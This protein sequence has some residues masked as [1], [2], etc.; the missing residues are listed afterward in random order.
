MI[1][2]HSHILFGVDDGA[3]DYEESVKMLKEARKAGFDTIIAT[4]H[5][6]RA[7][8]D[9]SA[10]KESMGRL[11]PVAESI[12]INLIQGYE[13]NISALADDS[14]EGAME[15]CTE[16]TKT[17]LLEMNG[18]QIVS[19]WERIVIHFQREGADIIIAHPERYPILYSNHDIVSRMLEVGCKLQVDLAVMLQRGLFNKEKTFVKSL[20]R[21]NCVRWAASDA[22]NAEDYKYFAEAFRK[23]ADQS[24]CTASRNSYSE[25]IK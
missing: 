4:P 12:G 18:T 11:R 7:H 10:V 1:D 8:F 23:Y 21:N 13:Y 3:K 5:V 17:I 24:M 9:K 16:G 22:H 25:L 15:Y 19:N 2:I 14:I 6:K 20:L